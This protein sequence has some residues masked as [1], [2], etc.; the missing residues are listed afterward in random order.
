MTCS[1]QMTT[2]S[3]RYGDR[4][5][6]WKGAR[7][8]QKSY[9]PRSEV[10]IVIIQIARGHPRRMIDLRV[11]QVFTSR[12][13]AS[14]DVT[15]LS[16]LG[17]FDDHD[18]FDRWS[19]A[20]ER[21]EATRRRSRSRSHDNPPPSI[22][23]GDRSLTGDEVYQRRLQMS[24]GGGVALRPPDV[25]VPT[26]VPS[27]IPPFP[28]SDGAENVGG[29]PGLNS[30][31]PPPP[32]TQFDESGEEAYLRRVAMSK[33]QTAR[34]PSPPPLAYNP[35][36]P[37]SVP[38]PPPP[39]SIQATADERAKAAA[40]I[41]ARLSALKDS[42]AATTQPMASVP[43]APQVAEAGGSSSQ[44][45][46]STSQIRSIKVVTEVRIVSPSG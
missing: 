41:A 5:N 36:A 38:P 27:H 2:T 46:V 6:E 13:P 28:P 15:Y 24:R 29:I 39:S 14:L 11:N 21:K 37:P 7:A 26:Q 25:V 42:A 34:P 8:G 17:R 45:C 22:T 16:T 32:R 31:A 33:Q 10:D 44:R 43:T 40:A 18:S 23:E 35:F 9:A 1:G 20:D 19:R 4:R 30:S 3:T 12:N